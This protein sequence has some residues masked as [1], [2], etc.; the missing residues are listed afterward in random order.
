MFD[1][2]NIFRFTVIIKYKWKLLLSWLNVCP[3]LKPGNLKVFSIIPSMPPRAYEEFSSHWEVKWWILPYKRPFSKMATQKT[4]GQD[5][6]LAVELITFIFYRV[7]LWLTFGEKFNKNNMTFWKNDSPKNCGCDILWTVGW[8]AFK[9][10]VVV[11]WVFL[12]IWLTL[13]ENI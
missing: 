7:V 1:G 5:I 4:C 2:F 12:K 11:L 3:F 8:I 9:F 10:V 6:L 13:G